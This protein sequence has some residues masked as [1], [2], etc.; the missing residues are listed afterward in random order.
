MA[1]RKYARRML[2]GKPQEGD[3][4]T[5]E[6]N[7][8]IY[9]QGKWY[10][11]SEIPAELKGSQTVKKAMGQSAPAK[12]KPAPKP[13]AKAASKPAPKATP[14]PAAKPKPKPTAAK[15][16]AKEYYGPGGKPK[17]ESL[18]S[19]VSKLKEMGEASKKRQ[20]EMKKAAEERRKKAAQRG[21]RKPG[22]MY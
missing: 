15:P 21:S 10:R 12:P 8:F 9:L 3:V 2:S 16:A 13:A 17:R 4:T 6:G 20:A 14:K 19:Q 7:K 5:K 1:P 22:S 18:K 11:P